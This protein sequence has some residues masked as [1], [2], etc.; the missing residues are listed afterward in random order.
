LDSS[1]GR[2]QSIVGRNTWCEFVGLNYD[3]GEATLKQVLDGFCKHPQDEVRRA[4]LCA[5][6]R[7]RME[8]RATVKLDLAKTDC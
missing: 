5:L 1:G 7:Q 8:R 3:E 2:L 6:K 4:I